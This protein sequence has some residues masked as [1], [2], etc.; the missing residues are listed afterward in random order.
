MTLSRFVSIHTRRGG[1][2]CELGPGPTGKSMPRKGPPPALFGP[3][4]I[5]EAPGRICRLFFSIKTKKTQ[6]ESSKSWSTG[7][8]STAEKKKARSR[9][10]IYRAR[11]T[12]ALSR[13]PGL[14]VVFVA[15]VVYMVADILRNK[16]SKLPLSLGLSLGPLG[17]GAAGAALG[18]SLGVIVVSRRSR[19]RYY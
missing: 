9:F 17:A 4:K 6:K 13:P 15:V 16:V 5:G 11:P 7:K 14:L 1:E 2:T 19:F 3:Q 18:L 8:E 10:F 12:I